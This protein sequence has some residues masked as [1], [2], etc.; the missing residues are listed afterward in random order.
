[1]D[2]FEN[3]SPIFIKDNNNSFVYKILNKLGIKREYQDYILLILI[4]IIILVSYFIF[5]NQSTPKAEKTKPPVGY[6][7]YNKLNNKT[8]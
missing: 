4:V 5:K 6:E 8:Q 7:I 3:Q 2:Q 1:M